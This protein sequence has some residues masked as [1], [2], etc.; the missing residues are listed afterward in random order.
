MYSNYNL[1]LGGKHLGYKNG[2]E[3]LPNELIK[4]IQEYV[5]GENIYIPRKE[6]NRKDWG[7][8]TKTKVVLK[9]RNMEIYRK[10][11]NGYRVVD[12]AAEYHISTQGIYK[13]LSR[14][15]VK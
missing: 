10:Y 11:Q 13:I 4:Q 8:D 12:L 2:N 5:D 14:L 9:A 6:E 3:I 7:A 1:Y 15:K